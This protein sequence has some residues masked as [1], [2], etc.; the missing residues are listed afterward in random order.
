MATAPGDTTS[1]DTITDAE[2]NHVADTDTLTNIIT[3]PNAEQ[4]GTDRPLARDV[5]SGLAAPTGDRGRGPPRDPVA[6]RPGLQL[7][8]NAEPGLHRR[9][10]AARSAAGDG[11][12]P[13]PLHR[14]RRELAP[15][16]RAGPRYRVEPAQHDQRR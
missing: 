9:R 1:P 6:E 5:E 8:V 16:G 2:P 7:P 12:L 14:P 3:D 10:L 11:Q 15:V 13:L 4:L